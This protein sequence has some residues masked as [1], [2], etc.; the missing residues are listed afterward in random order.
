MFKHIIA[1]LKFTP[2]SIGAL[3][4]ALQLARSNSA[5]LLIFHG[6]DYKLEKYNETDLPLVEALNEVDCLY[7]EKVEPLLAQDDNVQF[8]RYPADSALDLCRLAKKVDTDLIVLGCH[9]KPDKMSLGRVDYVGI[10]ILEKA[11]CPVMLIPVK[12]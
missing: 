5:K 10:T 8:E 3:E 1:A 11:P 7:R 2:A 9:Q 4:K 6:L 12:T